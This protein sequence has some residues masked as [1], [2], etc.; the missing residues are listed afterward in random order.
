MAYIVP[1]IV[2]IIYLSSK[3][4]QENAMLFIWESLMI[5]K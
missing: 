5:H 4:E 3:I 2:I 1:C